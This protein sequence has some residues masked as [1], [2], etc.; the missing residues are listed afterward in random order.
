MYHNLIFVIRCLNKD[1]IYSFVPFFVIY[2]CK[3]VV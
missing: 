1:V 3:A 2:L